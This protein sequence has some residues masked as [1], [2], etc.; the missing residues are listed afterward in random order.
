MLP[1][2]IVLAQ[3]SSDLTTREEKSSDNQNTDKMI[4]EH[5][6]LKPNGLLS[7][8]CECMIKAFHTKKSAN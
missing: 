2:R 4:S 7:H 3:D 1:S 6:I 5:T 8:Y